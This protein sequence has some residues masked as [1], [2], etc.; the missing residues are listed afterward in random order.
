MTRPINPKTA[1]LLIPTND[2]FI[3]EAVL[4]HVHELVNQ[5]WFSVCPLTDIRKILETGS[6][7]AIS[8]LD[9]YHCVHYH[10]MS[11]SFRGNLFKQAMEAV[12]IQVLP[13]GAKKHLMQ[14]QVT[15]ADVKPKSWIRPFISWMGF[16]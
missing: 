10:T 14:S 9:P 7:A 12:G 2:E 4:I 1:K 15:P 5:G 3:M 6:R 11:D 13:E 16:R 8:K